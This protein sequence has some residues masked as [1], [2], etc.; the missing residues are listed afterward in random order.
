MISSIY[1]TNKILHK[2]GSR[3]GKSKKGIEITTALQKLSKKNT[4]EFKLVKN[5]LTKN[6]KK[7]NDWEINFLISIASFNNLS[8][9]QKQIINKI[10][11]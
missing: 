1:N 4:K 6:I 7:L 10:K 2:S 5:I 11:K 3:K 9:K 8:D